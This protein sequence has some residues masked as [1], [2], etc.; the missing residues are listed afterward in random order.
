MKL[1]NKLL[2]FAFGSLL[3]AICILGFTAR[4]FLNPTFG[5]NQPSQNR[6]GVVTTQ[7]NNFTLK[8]PL[9]IEKSI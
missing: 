5:L 7:F 1:S 6:I 4:H 2:L 8:E 3:I 9:N